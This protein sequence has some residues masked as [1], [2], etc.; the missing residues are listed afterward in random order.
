MEAGKE[1]ITR[2]FSST[3][4]PLVGNRYR[5]GDLLGAG[6][7]GSVYRAYDHL[8]GGTVALKQVTTQPLQPVE[9]VAHRLALAHEFQALASLRHP[10]IIAVQDYG[11]DQNGQPYFTMELLPDSRPLPEVGQWQS[12]ADKVT[13]LWQLLSALAYLHRRGIIHRDLKPGNVLVIG[14][15][16]KVLD[17]GLAA[18]IG[19]EA[20]SAGTLWYMAPELLQGQ[21]ASPASDLYAV[22]MLAYELLA[23][24]HPF[25][26]QAGDITQLIFQQEPDFTYVDIEPPLQAIVQR[27]LAKQPASRFGEATAVITALA[28]ATGFALPTETAVTRESFLQA[29]PF[30][31]RESELSQLIDALT[32]AQNG[33][34]SQWLIAGESGIGKTRLLQELRTQAL[35]QGMLVLRGQAS[36]TSGGTYQMWRDAL[37]PLLLLAPPD[38]LMAAV[39]R[40]VIPDV[41]QMLIRPLP[42]LP[43]LE[44]QATQT[45]LLLA[46][47]SLI[48]QSAA[49]QPLLFLLE[50]LHW[51][52]DNSLE[53]L[54]QLSR[55]LDQL[56]LL[57][58]GSY[59]SGEMPLLPPALHSFQL[60]PLKRLSP[61]S[62]AALSEAMLGVNGRRPHLL[63]F[64]QQESEGNT[65]FI[66][67]VMRALAEEA[68]RLDD[69]AGITLPEHIFSGGIEE[70][71]QRRLRRIAAK[72]QPLLQLAAVAG[73]QLDLNL[74]QHLS[75][76][77]DME[78]WLTAGA[79][80]TVLARPDGDWRWQFSHDKLR[81]GLLR[82]ITPDQQQVYH[83]Q[84]S[85]AIEQFYA[86]NLTTHYADLA[87]H[88]GRAGL[89]DKERLYL[90]RAGAAAQAD[91]ANSAAINY[92]ER[93]LPLLDDD[94]ARAEV[95]L[96]LGMVLKVV[97]EWS[98]AAE[99]VE[100]ALV[101]A[102]SADQSAAG[103]QPLP[104]ITRI[105]R[106][107]GNLARSR[108]DYPAALAWLS[109]AEKSVHDPAELGEI[110]LEMGTVYY[111]QG[112][113][114]QAKAQLERSLSTL[115]ESD[116]QT[117]L[118]DVWRGL[119]SIF[120]SQG[121][122]ATAQSHYQRSLALS[123]AASYKP[124]SA[125][126]LNNLGNLAYRQGDYATAQQRYQESLVLRQE[127]GDV[128]GMA[129]SLSNLGIV[130]FH[131]QDYETARRY[132]EEALQLRRALG[133]EATLG[134]SLD[135]L[136]LIATSLGDYATSRR[137]GEEALAVRRKIGD[138]QGLAITL[139]NQAFAALEQGEYET[140]E[141]YYGES[142]A[143]SQEL[144]DKR[145]I[146]TCL[147]GMAGL[148]ARSRGAWT[149][150]VQ[151]AENGRQT[152]AE[153]GIEMER[154]E[155]RM[156]DEVIAGAK[157]ELVIT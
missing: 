77:T 126:S 82:A 9:S 23:G 153:L 7:M 152:L 45:R 144:E 48:R 12:L 106:A 124:G 156:Y 112:E 38:D 16:V 6:G 30:I 97:G 107:L 63:A 40:V 121:D 76:D 32:K 129:A 65:F 15:T 111:Q 17:F 128:S 154:E 95:L 42:P 5:L 90:Q 64:L 109:Q 13:L 157:R 49:V 135:N 67:E 39:L 79:N 4:S 141:R 60:L 85:M 62:V 88:F 74:L 54:G 29:A 96:N 2:P 105:T 35:V 11:F 117:L 151:L 46:V 78:S 14:H 143:L 1:M 47:A 75:P 80:A 87:H 31:G 81:E 28:N 27:L 102:E 155:Q 91:F 21:P 149:E 98:A 122:Y 53:L 104:L 3:N 125:S 58:V 36:R 66:V 110:M 71:V 44:P 103:R 93:L 70:V 59:R 119:G 73:R 114:A 92:Y 10:H 24:W 61:T 69:V 84:I 101:S 145:G 83:A 120:Y 137:L 50:D 56:P 115:Q 150:A 43:P 99:R 134:H 113:Y 131:Q 138:K 148:A 8:T 142:L 108:G 146:G 132:W 72:H 26:G 147:L 51:A 133:D 41:E 100:A 89:V 33:T 136:A 25:A 57:I 34:S 22:G 139:G 68:G 130:P 123:Q 19:Q 55:L 52:D 86:D 140:A 118:S 20:V 116:N 37:R 127:M 18:L 94:L